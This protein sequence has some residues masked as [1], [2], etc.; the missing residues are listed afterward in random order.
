M[1][2]AL[3][4]AREI[5]EVA[6][7]KDDTTYRLVGYRILGAMQLTTGQ[8]REALES[9]QR[10]ERYRDPVRQKLLSYRFGIDPGLDVLFY[11]IW[12]LMFL[13]LHD[14]TERVR[15]QVWAELAT[16]RHAPTLAICKLF[17]GVWPELAIG[18]FE[19]CERH[20]AELVTLCYR[21]EGGEFSPFGR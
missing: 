12:A 18:N 6:D 9:V 5:V 11:K 13:G 20:S 16:H 15:E 1:E 17:A 7:R 8:N 21:K 19:A 4:L 10:A 14:Q 3:A 2:P